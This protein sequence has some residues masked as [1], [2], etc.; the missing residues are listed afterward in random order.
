MM[1]VLEGME[2][3]PEAIAGGVPVICPHEY[4]SSDHSPMKSIA[5]STKIRQ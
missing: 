1:E 4:L 2:L 3:R 5:E